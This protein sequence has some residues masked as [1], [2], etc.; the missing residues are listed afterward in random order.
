MAEV[1]D[2]PESGRSASLQSAPGFRQIVLLVGLAAA[3]A[4]GIAIAIWAQSPNYRVLFPVVDPEEMGAIAGVLESADIPYEYD[5][6]SGALLV[7]SGKANQAQMLLA[8]QGLPQS[9][10]VTVETLFEGQG[11]STSQFMENKFYGHALEAKLER[12]IGSLNTVKAAQVSLGIPR[13]SVFL[14]DRQ[15]PT[16]SVVIHLFPGRSLESGQAQAISHLVASSV[17][18]LE[19]SKVTLL[20]SNGLLLSGQNSME[21][22]AAASSQFDYKR[23]LETTFAENIDAL[24][25]PIIGAGRSRTKV[26]AQLDFTD[27]EETAERFDPASQVVRSEVTSEQDTTGALSALGIPGALSNQPPPD[28]QPEPAEDG[29]APVP[30]QRSTRDVTMNYEMDRTISRIRVQTGRIER[31]SV[32]VVVDYLPGEGGEPAPLSDTQLEE[33]RG[34]VREAVGFDEARGDTVNLINLPFQAVPEPAPVEPPPFWEQPWVLDIGKVVIGGLVALAL[35]IWVVRPL[36]QNLLQAAQAPPQEALPFG[37]AGGALEHSAHP[38]MTMVPRD[39]PMQIAHNMATN[40]PKRIAQVVKD[41][42][43]ADE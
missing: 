14:R 18:G 30:S 43:A 35:V 3:V 6:T 4:V 21:G 39:D 24:L 20:D 5:A 22:M 7:A 9:R 41:W 25:T 38:E 8:G 16:A 32:A 11:Y 13:Q 29:A 36:V 12:I 37:V 31:L 1:Q 10:G 27:M 23:R 19:A 28:A 34:L 42:V 2:L 15:E 26:V 40:D 33:L 17:P